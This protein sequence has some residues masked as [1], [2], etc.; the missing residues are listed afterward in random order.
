MCGW[1]AAHRHVIGRVFL[2]GD[3]HARPA[4]EFNALEAGEPCPYSPLAS[5][6]SVVLDAVLSSGVRVSG[7]ARG[8]VPG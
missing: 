3:D 8:V 5:L 4:I 6:L 7:G 2:K 1:Y